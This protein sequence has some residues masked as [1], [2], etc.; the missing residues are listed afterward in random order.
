MTALVR[1]PLFRATWTPPIHLSLAPHSIRYE[2][3][4]PG[5]LTPHQQLVELRRLITEAQ[6]SNSPAHKRQVIVSYPHLRDLLEM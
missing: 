2:S 4:T 5:K 3:S 6:E 1:Q